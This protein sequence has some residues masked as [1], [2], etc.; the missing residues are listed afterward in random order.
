MFM[1]TIH[2]ETFLCYH[3]NVFFL[4]EGEVLFMKLTGLDSA[5][6][7]GRAAFSMLGRD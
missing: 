7:Y 4:V 5:F 2:M 6:V 1:S 3:G